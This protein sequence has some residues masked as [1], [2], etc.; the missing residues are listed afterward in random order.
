MRLLNDRQE[1][2]LAEACDTLRAGL[3]PCTSAPSV[4]TIYNVARSIGG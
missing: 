2:F 3:K 1:A 4:M